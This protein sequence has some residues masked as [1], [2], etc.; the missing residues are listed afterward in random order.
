[1]EDTQKLHKNAIYL[2]VMKNCVR[3]CQAF[4][5]LYFY[6][7][8]SY[9]LI[10]LDWV[11]FLLKKSKHVEKQHFKKEKKKLKEVISELNYSKCQA[12][13]K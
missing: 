7:K 9:G 11:V 10:I 1:M 6:L 8:S 3:F 12:K 2:D 4:F 5:T 13:K